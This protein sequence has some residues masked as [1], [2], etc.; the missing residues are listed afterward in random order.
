MPSNRQATV[1]YRV[2]VVP[3]RSL[4]ESRFVRYLLSVCLCLSL[5]LI[6]SEL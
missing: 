4:A 1:I 2:P 6:R 5:G 3:G